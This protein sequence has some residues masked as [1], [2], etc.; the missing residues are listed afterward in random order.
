MMTVAAIVTSV[1]TVA[2]VALLCVAVYDPT[3]TGGMSLK[4][5]ATFCLRQLGSSWPWR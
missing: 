5:R 2:L 1:A 3:R 4:Q